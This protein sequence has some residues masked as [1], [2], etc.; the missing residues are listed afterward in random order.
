MR[1]KIDQIFP[2][3]SKYFVVIPLFI[4][5]CV[6]P[7]P[8]VTTG[9]DLTNNNNDMISASA[10]AKYLDDKLKASERKHCDTCSCANRDL[11]V[12][13]DTHTTYSI[14]TQTMSQQKE[15]DNGLCLRCSS[16]LDS[17]SRSSSPFLLKIKSSDSVIS[18]TKSSIS[19]IGSFEH[20]KDELVVNPILGH[21]RL[22]DRGTAKLIDIS[23]STTSSILAN[24]SQTKLLS[25]TQAQIRDVPLNS[26]LGTSNIDN[27][28]SSL[29]NS[30]MAKAG[31]SQSMS[32]KAS[33]QTDGARI[34]ENFNRNLIRSIK[35]SNTNARI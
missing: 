4:F 9:G 22:C 11:T 35:V 32:S 20:K 6:W 27:K 24:D 30:C 28:S 34:F 26:K 5:R 7:I 8:D 3:S 29:R 1:L 16:H 17:P 15:K 23:S 12:L 18:E 19:G 21:H 33:S 2:N 13:A 25:P 14:S 31:S 10:M